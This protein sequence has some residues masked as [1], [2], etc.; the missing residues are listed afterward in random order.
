MRKL[1]LRKDKNYYLEYISFQAF[2]FALFFVVFFQ[3]KK[4]H[5]KTV[6]TETQKIWRKIESLQFEI[7]QQQSLLVRFA[8]TGVPVKSPGLPKLPP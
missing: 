8:G 2:L 4:R 6:K 3:N 1:L 7:G 5:N